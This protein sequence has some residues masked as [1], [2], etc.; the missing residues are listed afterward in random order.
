MAVLRPPKV[1]A[2]GHGII[3][4]IIERQRRRKPQHRDLVTDPFNVTSRRDG[5][6]TVFA[7]YD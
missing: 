2:L 7:D 6:A 1:P 3:V 4:E 5:Q